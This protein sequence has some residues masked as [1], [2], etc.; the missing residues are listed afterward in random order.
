MGSFL[1]WLILSD[2]CLSF[3]ASWLCYTL[4]ADCSTEGVSFLFEQKK[5]GFEGLCL[6]SNCLVGQGWLTDVLCYVVRVEG[7]L[8]KQTR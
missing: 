5:K 7:Y 3:E 1:P 6:G 2:G 4:P 8:F